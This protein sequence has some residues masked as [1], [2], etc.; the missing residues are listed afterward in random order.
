MGGGGGSTGGGGGTPSAFPPSPR[1]ATPRIPPI[2]A[3]RVSVPLCVV[4]DGAARARVGGAR[5]PRQPCRREGEARRKTRAPLPASSTPRPPSPRPPLTGPG[6]GRDMGGRRGGPGWAGGRGPTG[7]AGGGRVL[8]PHRHHAALAAPFHARHGVTAI[9]LPQVEGGAGGVGGHRG[10]GRG[11]VCSTPIPSPLPVRRPHTCSLGPAAAATRRAG[12]M[13]TR[14]TGRAVGRRVREA[15]I[16]G[17]EKRKR[18][19]RGGVRFFV[20]FRC[21]VSPP[22]IL[23]RPAE[24]ER[25]DVVFRQ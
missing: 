5:A 3:V 9:A 15:S 18:S 8:P 24:R 23:F 25:G 4:G 17:K 19:K 10:A 13:V 20:S 2:E 1:F 22:R 14:A 21:R 16:A 7:E 6:S 11:P 12:V